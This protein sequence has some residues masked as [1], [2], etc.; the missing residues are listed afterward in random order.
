MSPKRT[1]YEAETVRAGE[2]DRV[3]RR[4]YGEGQTAEQRGR[5]ARLIDTFTGRFGGKDALLFSSP[6]RTEL[7]G[8]H[9]D[10]NRG[11]VLAAGI[12]LDKIAAVQPRSDMQATVVTEDLD[13]VI[14]VDLNDLAPRSEEEGT[15]AALVRG[16][17]AYLA[18]RGYR[19]GGFDAYVDS[20][21]AI[22]SGLSSSASVEVLIAHILNVLFN[23]G[24]ADSVTLALAGQFA[25]NTFFNKP[26]GLMDQLACA[27]GAVQFI[28]LEDPRNPAVSTVDVDFASQGYRLCTV[29]TGG[30]H[31]D[32][33]DAYASIPAEMR[34]VAGALGCGELRDGSEEQ[35]LAKVSEVRRA[36]GDRAVLRAFHFFRENERVPRMYAALREGEIGEYLELADESG[37]SSWMLLQNCIPP[38]ADKEQPIPYVITL[39]R[40]IAPGGIFR[41]MGGGFAGSIQGYVPETEWKGYHSLMEELLGRGTVVPLYIRPCGVICVEMER[42]D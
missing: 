13:E 17:A 32:L 22:G 19:V 7:G 3:L 18:E 2:L 40:S 1:A 8:N 6:G 24:T 26:S 41:V 12:H 39:S 25:E 10:H 35:L 15:A 11:R 4:L 37:G 33:T 31:A 27:L 36:C 20:R 34:C 38:G 28:D 5:Y 30:S 29:D 9:T 16:C 23:D 21:V 42:L 14:E